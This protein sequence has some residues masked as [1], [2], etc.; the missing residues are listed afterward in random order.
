MDY[1][2]EGD[3]NQSPDGTFVEGNKKKVWAQPNTGWYDA[4]PTGKYYSIMAD[5]RFPG[6][7]C[8]RMLYPKGD[9]EVGMGSKFYQVRL[10]SPQTIANLEFSWLF[11]NG[12]S[13]YNT[14]LNPPQQVG[15]GKIGPCI[16]WGEVGGANEKRGTRCMIWWN[17]QGSNH[18]K[19]VFSP[20]CQDQ[21]TGNQ[22]IQPI[23]YSKAIVL[24]Q[25]YKFRIQMQGGPSGFAK[26]WITY[27]GE[28]TETL[29]AEVGK[30]NLQATANDDV[31]YDF[32]FFS[33]G[34][35]DAY[36]FPKD[37]Y[38]RHGGIRYW[39]GEAYWT[40]DAGNGGSG[41]GGDGVSITL[42]DTTYDAKGHL[43]LT[44]R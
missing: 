26:Y 3:F 20:S 25:V 29:L 8:C 42:G 2:Y 19:P 41:G 12:F 6:G 9:A 1:K 37:C 40:A 27:P 43:T 22:L 15:G 7:K 31:L 28:N 10:P 14:A 30:Q 17:A 24:D 21:R 11:E 16:N 34:A 4:D 36:S 39:S 23:K 18:A 38:A 35:G 33:G 5:E 44:P 13:F 32:A